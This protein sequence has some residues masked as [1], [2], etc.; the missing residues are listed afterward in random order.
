MQN[1]KGRTQK[2]YDNMEYDYNTSHEGDW[3]IFG[4]TR[5]MR[6][7]IDAV[8]IDRPKDTSIDAFIRSFTPQ[9]NNKSL[10]A[11]FVNCLFS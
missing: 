7:G 1:T 4:C 10:L 3:V 9:V 11:L 5:K 2:N 8:A 6:I